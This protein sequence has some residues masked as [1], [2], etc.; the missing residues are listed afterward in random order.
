MLHHYNLLIYSD[1]VVQTLPALTSF[2]TLRMYRLHKGNLQ[3]RDGNCEVGQLFRIIKDSEPVNGKMWLYILS[4][5][6]KYNEWGPGL[7]GCSGQQERL[8]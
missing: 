8:I 6:I 1:V 7:V 2:P 5:R 4:L 3:L